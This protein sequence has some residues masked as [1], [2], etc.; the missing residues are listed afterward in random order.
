M[1][2]I[3]WRSLQWPWSS[4][5]LVQVGKHTPNST[6]HSLPRWARRLSTI[7]DVFQEFP[8][9]LY[10]QRPCAA[11]SRREWVSFECPQK[12]RTRGGMRRNILLQRDPR[13]NED[14]SERAKQGDTLLSSRGLVEPWERLALAGRGGTRRPYIERGDERR[15]QR[16][17]LP[18]S[19]TEQVP[20]PLRE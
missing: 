10:H 5:G 11:W 17:R 1:T 3:V 8:M 18:G 14:W 19:S 13:E 16:P 12:R 20:V 2:I 9:I 15:C 7:H 4:S 6:T